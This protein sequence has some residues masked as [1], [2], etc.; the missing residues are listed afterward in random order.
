[1]TTTKSSISRVVD[2]P[3]CATY[4]DGRLCLTCS[5]AVKAQ[6]IS[7][8]VPSTLPAARPW[9]AE[10]ST[11]DFS[12]SE[13]FTFA[14]VLDGLDAFEDTS[15]VL[16]YFEKPWKW[17]GEHTRWVELDSPGTIGEDE[18]EYILDNGARAESF[19]AW[20]AQRDD[21]EADMGDR[22]TATVDELIESHDAVVEGLKRANKKLTV[23]GRPAGNLADFIAVNETLHTDD[24]DALN[25]LEVGGK[26]LLGR[27][28]VTRVK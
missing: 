27:A 28:T 15:S 8:P 19:A 13:V 9:Y 1:M 3:V 24:I 11:A 10:G 23:D 4:P 20:K 26:I 16:Y 14:Q 18:A 6:I 21:D 5:Q 25:A 7:T 2:C 12:M 17:T 22:V